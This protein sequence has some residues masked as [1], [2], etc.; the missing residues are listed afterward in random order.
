MYTDFVV[1]HCQFS[2]N[3]YVVPCQRQQ[4]LVQNLTPIR[5]RDRIL[6][7]VAA[8][9]PRLTAPVKK[10]IHMTKKIFLENGREETHF[11]KIATYLEQRRELILARNYLHHKELTFFVR[12]SIPSRKS[13][14]IFEPLA[15][16]DLCLGPGKPHSE[17][18]TKTRLGTDFAKKSAKLRRKTAQNNFIV[19]LTK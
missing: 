6:V 15:I 10:I 9:I 3:V 13:R 1:Q 17:H 12:T 8:E 5:V 11:R 14:Y 18:S 19:C 16:L 4:K 2:Y 7:P